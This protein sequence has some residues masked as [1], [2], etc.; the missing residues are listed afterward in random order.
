LK[1]QYAKFLSAYESKHFVKEKLKDVTHP[2]DIVGE[3]V[4]GS[5]SD[6]ANA[7][8]RKRLDPV[9]N[10]A[11]SNNWQ[12]PCGLGGS[13]GSRHSFNSILAGLTNRDQ[14]LQERHDAWA[15]EKSDILK[16]QS[17]EKHQRLAVEVANQSY[18]TIDELTGITSG[19]LDIDE[20]FNEAD[21]VVIFSRRLFSKKIIQYTREMHKPKKNTKG[22]SSINIP[23]TESC[24]CTPVNS[25]STFAFS[26]EQLRSQLQALARYNN[27]K[28]K[29]SNNNQSTSTTQN[30]LGVI[31]TSAQPSK[32][33]T[34]PFSKNMQIINS[35]E[36]QIQ[37][38]FDKQEV[39]FSKQLCIADDSNTNGHL[40]HGQ[41]IKTM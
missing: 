5:S 3:E 16:K 18:S 35:F 39:D 32:G 13:R 8:K 34:Q 14:T 28:K 37:G 9:L 2:E 38:F 25:D 7:K 24:P 20:D 19:A 17:E 41:E 36:Q 4:G 15:Q 29:N 23:N 22:S 33:T 1:K 30:P 31:Q 12:S 21:T 40:E 26:R 27:R 11:D 10:K 6:T